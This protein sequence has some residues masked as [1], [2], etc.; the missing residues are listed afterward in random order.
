MEGKE[1]EREREK[2]REINRQRP[3]LLLKRLKT[4]NLEIEENS[5][6]KK[7]IPKYM[8]EKNISSDTQ[9]LRNFLP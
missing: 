7:I 5:R 9:H 3:D 8:L 2:E 1:K 6:I 4:E